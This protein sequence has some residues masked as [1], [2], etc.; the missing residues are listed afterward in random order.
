[1]CVELCTKVFYDRIYC[2][3]HSCSF[4][5]P[6]VFLR[7]TYPARLWQRNEKADLKMVFAF[8]KLHGGSCVVGLT[9]NSA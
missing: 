3:S 9:D 6:V 8:L 7:D 2:E 4:F 5:A 1:M